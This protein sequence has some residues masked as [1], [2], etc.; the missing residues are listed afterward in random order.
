MD[1]H[2]DTITTPSVTPNVP[3]NNTT[4]RVLHLRRAVRSSPHNRHT[5]TPQWLK[6]TK[7]SP[8]DT[9]K[10]EQGGL[11]K[12]ISITLLN[13]MGTRCSRWRCPCESCIV[14]ELSNK[15]VICAIIDSGSAVCSTCS[16]VIKMREEVEEKEASHHTRDFNELWFWD[17]SCFLPTIGWENPPPMSPVL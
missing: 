6:A 1:L 12:E 11:S 16:R 3:Y 10:T 2:H 15:G 17:V 14:G 13:L 4:G 7:P 5:H 9:I 8:A